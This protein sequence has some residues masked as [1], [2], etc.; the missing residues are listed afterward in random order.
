MKNKLRL[1]ILIPF[2]FLGIQ[3]NGQDISTQKKP[4]KLEVLTQDAV[5]KT[6]RITITLGA[7]GKFKSLTTSNGN[8]IL[9]SRNTKGFFLDL[10]KRGK[11]D[12]TSVYQK[13][14]NFVFVTEDKQF[15][16]T[17]SIQAKPTYV[18]FTLKDFYGDLPVGSTLECMIASNEKMKGLSYDYAGIEKSV[19]PK[20]NF[21]IAIEHLWE[22][23][24]GNSLGGFIYYYNSS[25]EAED[26]SIIRAW[27]EEN[28]PHPVVEGEWNY[29]RAKKWLADWQVMFADQSVM[30]IAPQVIDELPFYEKYFEMTGVTTI[31]LFT[32]IWHGGFWPRDKP[33]WAVD[34]IF[35]NQEKLRKF[36][37]EQREKGRSVNLHYVSGGIGVNDPLYVKPNLSEDLASW[38]DGT[39]EESLFEESNVIYFK[40][41]ESWYKLP[42]DF[43]TKKQL[44][45]F[46]SEPSR[47]FM[48]FDYVKIDNELIKV[49]KV[50]AGENGTWKFYIKNRKAKNTVKRNHTKGAVVKGMVLPYN[51]VYIPENNSELFKT[52]AINYASLLNDCQISNTSFDGAEIH[53]YDG[54][55]GFRKF[56]QIVY[57]N[58]DHPV[59]TRT[60]YGKEPDSG[61]IEYRLNQTKKF[62]TS[63]VGDHNHARA[64]L[65]L[66]RKS[67]THKSELRGASNLLAAHFMLSTQA[68]YNG[69]N[70]SVLRP[71]PMFGITLEDLDAYGRSE[72]LL[73]LLPKWKDVSRKLTQNQR[74][75]MLSTHQRYKGRLAS[76]IGYELRETDTEYLIYPI[77][78]MAQSKEAIKED[79]KK[80]PPIQLFHMKQEDGMFTPKA[81][82]FF[83]E[84]KFMSNKYE[85]QAPQF[86]I[87]VMMGEG[88]LVHP[89]LQVGK[90]K[91]IVKARLQLKNNETQYV[92]YRGGEKAKVYDKNWN[93]KEEVNAKVK[94]NFLAKKG[95]NIVMLLSK[96]HSNV[97]AELLL[98]TEGEP[99][100]VSK[101]AALVW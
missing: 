49:S 30:Y 21:H 55:W 39:L 81:N 63:P 59:V 96:N 74:E 87:R 90:S 57:E 48:K 29:E 35:G 41:K 68:A 37:L 1:L 32:N 28:I 70:F 78:M 26:E 13:D 64:S 31:N 3:L 44:V 34:G 24:K 33:N 65:R 89:M 54:K 51:V 66:E 47:P 11:V 80:D 73:K 67:R 86:I 19:G 18:A 60:S 2:L 15:Y 16:A 50:E 93:L 82:L 101:S 8:E 4:K 76:E 95:E 88:E 43:T 91:L 75:K 52:V 79:L 94:G 20:M 27:G 72:E 84:T 61:F 12:F 56:A 22:R 92:E 9:N 100:K 40:P 97:K 53:D 36:S 77:Q 38:V 10:P 58:L 6:D 83:G 5:L 45:G 69:R 17:F 46:L 62:L 25:P 23:Y 42:K 85:A 99:I 14:D 98:F 7:D 71:D